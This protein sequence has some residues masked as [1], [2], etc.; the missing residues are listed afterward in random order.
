MQKEPPGGIA[1]E[2]GG[3]GLGRSRGDLTTRLHLGVEQGQKP[4]S[5]VMTAG[6]REDPPQFEHVLK[7]IR[8]PRIGPGRPRTRPGRVRADQAYAVR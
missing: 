7:A 3:R 2:P 4:M 1:T 6:Q 8:V 5:I